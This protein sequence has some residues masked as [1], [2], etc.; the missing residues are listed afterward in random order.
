MLVGSDLPRRLGR[1]T[2]P[3]GDEDHLV[4]ER[5]LSMT[6]PDMEKT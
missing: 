4:P 1:L 6:G 3:A 5:P 2:D